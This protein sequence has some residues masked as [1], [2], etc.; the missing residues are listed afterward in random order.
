MAKEILQV[1][2]ALAFTGVLL[3]LRE[4]VISFDMK[5]RRK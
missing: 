4:M 1:G 5:K 2:S 3:L